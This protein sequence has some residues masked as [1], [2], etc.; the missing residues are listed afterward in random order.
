MY[1]SLYNVGKEELLVMLARS[2]RTQVVV[3]MTRY[4]IIAA[5]GC[6]MSLFTPRS[7]KREE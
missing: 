5:A 6:D 1:L 2:L 7:Q 4:R 3:T